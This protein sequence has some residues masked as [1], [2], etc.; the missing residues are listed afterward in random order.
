M[1]KEI[2][3][4]MIVYALLIAASVAFYVW[5][6]PAQVIITGSAKAEKF[7]PDTFPRFVTIVFFL[8]AVF[9]LLN[10]V[11][12]HHKEKRRA[13]APSGVDAPSGADAPK[14]PPT[15]RD[16]LA[17]F[18][19]YM[20]FLLVLLYGILFSKFGFVPAT[21]V[22]PPIVLFVIGCRKWHY[23]GIL[24]AFAA[25]LYVLFKYL[26]LVPVK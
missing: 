22:V 19:P 9:G 3:R 2:K 23:Y 11:R 10:C 20:I 6:I 1:K 26:L 15:F 4:D 8:S 18:I 16:R 5:V 21:I 25:V 12:L 7:S 24:Y 14:A 13:P 17:P